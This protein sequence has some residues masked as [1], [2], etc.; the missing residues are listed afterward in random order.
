M[1]WIILAF[2]L[3]G[4]FGIIGGLFIYRNNTKR[5]TELEGQIIRSHEAVERSVTKAVN[6]VKSEVEAVKN[7]AAK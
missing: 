6:E 1:G 7:Q 2:V 3:G 4:V 5:F